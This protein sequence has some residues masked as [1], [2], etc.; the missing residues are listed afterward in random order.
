MMSIAKIN[1]VVVAAAFALAG[2]GGGGGGSGLASTPTP[3]PPPS[4]PPPIILAAT[5]SQ[6]FAA[7][8]ASHFEGD[9]TPRLGSADQL[10][11]RYI[12]SSKSYEVQL[13]Q[14]QSWVPISYVPNQAGNP[15]NYAGGG[16]NLWLRSD[17]YQYSRLFEWSSGNAIVGHEA[18]G[19]ATPAGGMP[20]TGSASYAGQILGSTS[21]THAP[22][23]TSIDGTISLAFNFGAGNLSG[24]ISPVL[25][26]DFASYPLATLNFSNTVYS[27]GSTTFSGRFDTILA[28]LNSFAGLF[29]GPNAQELIGNFAFPYRSPIDDHTYQ[30]DGAFV[31][32]KGP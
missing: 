10:Q 17:G 16:V 18:I 23:D 12:Q 15:I 20:L 9:P 25:R 3:T 1:P 28:G 4:S 22:D 11:V 32:S 29:T 27:T 2:C 26:V 24:S 7:M 8:G 6:Q 5:T 13:P 19:M 14:S 31:G 30:A 21:E